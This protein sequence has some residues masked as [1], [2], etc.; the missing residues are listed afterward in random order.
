MLKGQN[1]IT[2]TYEGSGVN[3]NGLYYGGTGRLTI[4]HGDREA[5]L[6]LIAKNSGIYLSN[7]GSLHVNNVDL[8]CSGVGY[9]ITGAT[10]SSANLHITAS[11][12]TAA[13]ARGCI[14]DFGSIALTHAAVVAPAGASV[15][16]GAVVDKNG[17]EVIT[18][19]RIEPT[20]GVA[21]A[22]VPIS[23]TNMGNV[24][25]AGI[26]SGTVRFDAANHRLYL[27][28]V[29]VDGQD[30]PAVE[31]SEN[32]QNDLAI[33]VEGECSLISNSDAAIKWGAS[34][35]GQIISES[36]DG[37][38]SIKAAQG[39]CVALTGV[40]E[41]TISE[42]KRMELEGKN[43]IVSARGTVAYNSSL[44]IV[45]S[46][47]SLEDGKVQEQGISGF[48]GGI[49]LEKC[50][51]RESSELSIE[52][53]MIVS[54]SARDRAENCFHIVREILQYTVTHR[55]VGPGK[56]SVLK[57]GKG[58]DTQG[59][60]FDEG[61]GLQVVATPDGDA[62][63]ESITVNGSKE[64]KTGEWITLSENIEVVATFAVRKTPPQPPKV[65]PEDP[66]EPGKPGADL[67]KT[68]FAVKFSHTGKG[69][70]EV[71][72]VRKSGDKVAKDSK[73]TI[74]AKAEAGSELESLMVD[75]T[76]VTSPHTMTVTKD[77]RIVATFKE[78]VDK[79]KD[80]EKPG[81]TTSVEPGSEIAY[82][83][84]PNPAMHTVRVEGL[85][86]AET[87]LF[88]NAAGVLVLRARSEENGA[89]D[90]SMLSSGVY[91]VRVAGQ[92]VRF[93]KQ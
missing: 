88:Y 52:N 27:T 60:S 48:T 24:L 13:G 32:M 3:G 25:G 16:G 78:N 14:N 84:S 42:R 31:V 37:E 50:F 4:T 9:G 66:S 47:I 46:E 15:K 40:R 83:V 7:N 1:T 67:N 2:C 23:K 45:A 81:V 87:L 17:S 80:E 79:K 21:V 51:L 76:V 12:V 44:R 22:G 34:A 35:S 72:G 71:S 28:G 8:T 70:V 58:A 74:T 33:V 41:F 5:S 91:F 92:V 73:I 59:K 55:V 19:V 86:K 93:V 82:G 26:K 11:N 36:R 57:D 6:R 54:N 39:T 64:I 85:R 75:G 61:T 69:T 62:V 49:T 29:E 38:L 30:K 53:G 56:L 10:L 65:G 68:M 89:V 18:E 90:V 63:V 77:V 43:G 20:F